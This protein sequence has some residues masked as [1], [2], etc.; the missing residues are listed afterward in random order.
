MSNKYRSIFRKLVDVKF[1]IEK[2]PLNMF[3]GNQRIC[4]IVNN[5][6]DFWRTQGYRSAS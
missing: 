5:G 6:R 3:T 1:G 4:P 2:L